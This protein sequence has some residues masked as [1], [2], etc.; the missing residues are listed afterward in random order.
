MTVPA[1]FP[2]RASDSDRDWAIAEL[3]ERSAAGELSH[4]T[5]VR[6]MDA[7]LRARSRAE[8]AA[9]FCD[10]SPG[11]LSRRLCD[12]VARASAI[13]QRLTAA[14][15]LPRLP[16]LTLPGDPPDGGAPSG[17]TIGRE[18]GCDLVIGDLTVSRLHARL[19]GTGGHWLLCDLGS[20]NGTRRNGWRVS[21]PVPVQVGDQ[22]TF[23]RVTFIVAR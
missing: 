19:T 13:S 2:E 9:L 16:L 15:R 12:A 7:A 4:D 14:W 17:F 22:V 8:L 10:L 11:R 21:S 3:R 18:P 5:F 6:R 20:M 23:G 1:P